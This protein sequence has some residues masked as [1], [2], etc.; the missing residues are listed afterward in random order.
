VGGFIKGLL[1]SVVAAK[2]RLMAHRRGHHSVVDGLLRAAD[3]RLAR[4]RRYGHHGGHG[5]YRRTHW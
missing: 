3:R 1:L 2:L 5:H 4:P